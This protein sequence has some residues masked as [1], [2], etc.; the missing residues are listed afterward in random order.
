MKQ[1]ICLHMV[2]GPSQLDLYDYKPV[3]QTVVRQGSSRF[4]ADGS[5]ADDDDVGPGPI[6]DRSVDVQVRAQRRLRD[7]GERASAMDQK[8]GRRHGLYPQ[9][10]YR[11]DQPR[12]G[13]LLHADGQPDN[14][15][16]LP[17]G[18]DVVRTWVL[19]IT[20]CRRSW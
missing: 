17:G 4:G 6:S 11:R 7:V 20:I 9:H 2:G 3:M 16:A 15:S 1:V 12:A 8:D 14:G 10:A 13:D 18:L 19:S 5:A